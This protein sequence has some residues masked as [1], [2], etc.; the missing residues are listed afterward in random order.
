VS[1]WELRRPSLRLL[2]EQICTTARSI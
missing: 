2:N 1:A